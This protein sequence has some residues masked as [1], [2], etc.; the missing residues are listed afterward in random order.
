MRNEREKK[1]EDKRK[2][3]PLIIDMR[4]YTKQYSKS[5]KIKS[6]RIE[7]NQFEI[8]QFEMK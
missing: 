8:N 1:R 7:Y 3:K 2:Q 6:N 5:D 4:Y